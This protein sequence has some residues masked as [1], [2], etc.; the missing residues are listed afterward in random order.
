MVTAAIIMPLPTNIFFATGNK[1]KL[2]EARAAPWPP[3]AALRAPSGPSSNCVLAPVPQVS[4]I[5]ASGQALPFTVEA[6]K[7][8]L[9]ELQ[10]TV[11]RGCRA[12][13]PT[14]LLPENADGHLAAARPVRGAA[15]PAQP[16]THARH[17][18]VITRRASRTRFPRRSAG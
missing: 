2:E 13:Q 15:T 17:T 10:V 1:K 6:A 16:N 18:I 5:L 11:R 8:D 4:A 3:P 12:L 9:P 7:L 14:L